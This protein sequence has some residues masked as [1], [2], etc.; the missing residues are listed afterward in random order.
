MIG[1]LQRDTQQISEAATGPS[2]AL[3]HDCHPIDQQREGGLWM[4]RR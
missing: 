2:L 3:Y 4:C 1:L